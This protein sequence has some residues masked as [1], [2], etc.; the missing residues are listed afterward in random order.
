MDVEKFKRIYNN[1]PEKEKQT[2]IAIVEDKKITW[3]QAL[4]EIEKE[5]ALGKKIYKSLEEIGVI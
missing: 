1:L 2:T 3:E 4:K 5:T